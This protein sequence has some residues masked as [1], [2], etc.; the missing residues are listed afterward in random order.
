MREARLSNF[1]HL[2]A[3]DEEL[4]RLGLLAERC[5]PEDPNTCLLKLRQ[6]TQALA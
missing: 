2:K 1:G 6:L 4:V 5:F 3:H